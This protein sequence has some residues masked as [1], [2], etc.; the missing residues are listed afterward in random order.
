MSTANDRTPAAG[1]LRTLAAAALAALAGGCGHSF[2][3]PDVSGIDL[4][5]SVVP[6]YRDLFD[7]PA[8]TVVAHTADLV[9]RY[10]DY[11]DLYCSRIIGV[12]HPV[13]ST[14]A[15]GFRQFLTYEPNAEVMAECNRHFDRWT[16]L[17]ADL[18]DAMKCYRHFFPDA[19]IPNVYCHFSG[20]S[21]SLFVDSLNLSFSV[22]KYLGSDCDF[23]ARLEIPVYMRRQMT[24]EHIVPDVV[25]AMLLTD[26]PD[27]G[28][29]SDLLSAMIY[30]GKILYA[31]K[32]IVPSVADTVLFGYT[33]EQLEWCENCE[34]RMWGYLAENNYL[35]STNAMD[36]RKFVN[37]SPFT[38]FLGQ[39]SPGRAV[40]Y[41]GFN[42]VAAYMKERP[43]ETLRSLMATHDAQAIMMASRY[44]P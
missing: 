5:V 39:N 8:D 12:G 2:P 4:E 40:V 22:E 34:A 6:F 3:H 26:F 29:K 18:T 17:D 38:T 41:C 11:F 44:R 30:Q 37:D 25:R 28:D 27:D 1:T 21:Q 14:F 16:W 7:R 10:G 13:D 20:F 35:Y 32:C 42:I 23:Y 15:D 31:A 19:R 33:A 24:A 36:I 9:D 43:D